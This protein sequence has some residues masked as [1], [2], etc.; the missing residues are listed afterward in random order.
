MFFALFLSRKAVAAAVLVSVLC[1]ATGGPVLAK[2]LTPAQTI[3]SLS[4]ETPTSQP[5]VLLAHH[6]GATSAASSLLA[7]V[8]NGE[9][10]SEVLDSL[11][12]SL[13]AGMAYRRD[14][15]LKAIARKMGRSNNA[16]LL[17]I[18]GISGL[19][20]AQNITGLAAVN[21]GHE[22]TG[23]HEDEESEGHGHHDSPASSIMGVVGS[24]LTLG[25]I[26]VHAYL[27]HR[28]KKQ[29]IRRQQD[30]NTQILHVLG[31]LEEGMSNDQV[32]TEL[33]SLVGQ[34]ASREFMQL[35]Q[36]VHGAGR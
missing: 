31:E 33:V 2:T 35:W 24:G 36:A 23:H 28:Y 6:E 8:S 29:F 25:S 10:S 26:G 1:G 32:N 7:G 5:S 20:L 14:A 21:N 15:Q 3:N 12:G 22:S 16:F 27:E 19:S 30:I 11:W 9:A 4:V 34:R 18:A 13:L 17:S